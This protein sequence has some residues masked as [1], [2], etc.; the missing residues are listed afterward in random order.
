MLLLTGCQSGPAGRIENITALQLQEKM[1][2][3][4]TFAVVMTQTT[5]GHC[6][7]FLKEMD[8]YLKSHNMVL[9]DLVLDKEPNYDQSLKE[10]TTIFPKFTGTPDIYYIE[11]GAVQ[12]RFYDELDAGEGLDAKTFHTW[13]ENHNLLIEE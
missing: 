12:S 7:T 1:S 8:K 11:D 6:K 4:E 9:Y 10:L 2:N 3:K 13:A 5:C